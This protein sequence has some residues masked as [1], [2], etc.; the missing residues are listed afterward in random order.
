MI[1][2]RTDFDHILAALLIRRDGGYGNSFSKTCGSLSMVQ[3]NESLNIQG[4]TDVQ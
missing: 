3:L 4:E 1:L 2:S